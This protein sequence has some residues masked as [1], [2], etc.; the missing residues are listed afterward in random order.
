MEEF[1]TGTISICRRTVGSGTTY[2]KL[3][4]SSVLRTKVTVLV[5][6]PDMNEG[7]VFSVSRQLATI[8]G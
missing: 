4:L 3:N 2:L 6:D 1:Q 7:K 5:Y 8:G